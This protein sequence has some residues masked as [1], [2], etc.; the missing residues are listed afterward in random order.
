MRERR[1]IGAEKRGGGERLMVG[2]NSGAGK[3]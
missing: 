3:I 1:L 2:I